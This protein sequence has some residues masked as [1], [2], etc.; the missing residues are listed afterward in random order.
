MVDIIAPQSAILR[1]IEV[2]AHLPPHSAQVS[3]ILDELFRG[4]ATGGE[5]MGVS[6]EPRPGPPELALEELMEFRQS[7]DRMIPGPVST[8]LPGT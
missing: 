2:I 3:T 4:A 8:G 6:E 5:D 7:H 1:N